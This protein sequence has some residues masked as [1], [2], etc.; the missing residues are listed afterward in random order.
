MRK[1]RNG[2]ALWASGVLG[3]LLVISTGGGVLAAVP[4]ELLRGLDEAIQGF[5]P[6]EGVV[7]FAGEKEVYVDVT[8]EKGAAVGKEY[9]VE[10]PGETLKH[11][12]TGEVLGRTR[13][14]VARVRITWIRKK[15]SKA[16]IVESEGAMKPAVGDLV[17]PARNPIGVFFPPQSKDAGIREMAEEVAAAARRV[18]NV[19]W[20]TSDPR[21]LRT[22]RASGAVIEAGADVGIG[23][24]VSRDGVTLV[25]ASASSEKEPWTREIPRE[26][27]REA[28]RAAA[29]VR[30]S[31]SA[32][33]AE[34]TGGSAEEETRRSRRDEAA[35]VEANQKTERRT[36]SANR[37]FH[38]VKEEEGNAAS[39]RL[40]FVPVAAVPAD[41]DGDGT[42]EMLLA[43]EK[44]LHV[45]ELSTKG[46]R[47]M[48][49][50]SLGWMARAFLLSAGD[51]DGDGRD[52]IFVTQKPG[53]YVT[54]IGYR[55][56]NGKLKKF[57]KAG[58]K[59]LRVMKIDGK[60]ELFAQRYGSSRPFQGKIERLRYRDGK[61][62][63]E[64]AVFP[65]KARLFGVARLGGGFTVS[66][67]YENHLLLFNPSGSLLWKSPLRYG[68]SNR[69][70]ESADKKN[71]EEFRTGLE[72]FDLD[73]DGTEDLIAVRN[74]LEG[75]AERGFI[76]LGRL[77][78]YSS[79]KIVGMQ[80]RGDRLVK[81]WETPLFDG[82][83][84]NLGIAKIERGPVVVVV[85]VRKTG[86]N[87]RKAELVLLPL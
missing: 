30:E 1:K 14:L 29:E 55:Y 42:D 37:G 75:G 31:E 76:R 47:E 32:E 43:E 17:R 45:F 39:F 5:L 50:L 84:T 7:I 67:D 51:I 52:E 8:A 78:R 22:S 11:P 64:P 2:V 83:L 4:Q 20:K 54:G 58:G 80:L 21:S 59:F 57:Y 73:G 68:G 27:L 82:E 24:N 79:G 18:P 65:G 19:E 63:S 56:R 77:Q 25:V 61:M 12:V 40:D 16:E 85:K 48:E 60:A 87:E 10:R 49:K 53:D 44:V 71:A 33:E 35:A 23:F 6:A 69:R 9:L 62:V 72:V 26:N 86:W 3:V 36:A 38:E 46:A 34:K 81:R 28:R 13:T 15:F 41:I 66:L 74:L 70:I